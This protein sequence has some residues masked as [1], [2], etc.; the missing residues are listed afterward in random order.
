MEKTIL[1]AGATG[2]L[3]IRIVKALIKRNANVVAI[4]RQSSDGEKIEEM[5]K[6]GVKVIEVDMLSL[7]ELTEACKGVSCVVSAL[8]GLR[9]AIVDLQSLLLDAA[10][11]ADVP[12][13]I[14][15]DFS[16]DIFEIPDG[17][18][19]NFDLRKEFHKKLDAAPVSSSAIMNG[20]FADVLAY[21]TPFYN[22]K[23]HTIAYWGDDPDFKVSFTTKDNTAAYTAEVAL[24]DTAPKILHIASFQLSANDLVKMGKEFK[25]AAFK[26]LPMGSLEAFS[27]YNKKQRADNPKGEEELYPA[28]QQS[29]YMHSM[30]SFSNDPVDNDRYKNIDWASAGEVLSKM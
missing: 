28:W 1:V 25:S 4:V 11:A 16:V 14:P 6:M 15:S 10:L 3:G 7:A 8:A 19:R 18:N 2:D 26:L 17:D 30:F 9:E 27:N 23:E 5:K 20:A 21:N 24:D 29:Q 12:R 22:V 13:F